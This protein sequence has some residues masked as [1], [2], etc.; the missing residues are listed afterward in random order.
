MLAWG[1]VFSIGVAA[2]LWEVAAVMRKKV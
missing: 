1:L 2:V